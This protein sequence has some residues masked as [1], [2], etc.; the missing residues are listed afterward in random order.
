MNTLNLKLVNTANINPTIFVDDKQIKFKK[1]S[2]GSIIAQTQTDKNEVELSI[3]KFLELSSPLWWFW[4]II[5]YIVGILGIFDVFYPKNCFAINCKIKVKLNSTNSKLDISF[6][7]IT[8]D[9]AIEYMPTDCEIEE[10]KNEFYLDKTAKKRRSIL[11]ITKIISW[12]VIP[13]VGMFIY[14]NI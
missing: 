10:I 9:K 4:G 5:Y 12:F 2:F 13:I 14:M 8:G 1:N 6:G 7:S 3:Y 11:L